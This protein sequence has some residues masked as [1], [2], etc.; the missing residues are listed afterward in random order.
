M[1]RRS[2]QR[3]VPVITVDDDVIV[4]FDRRRLEQLIARDGAGGG[5]RRQEPARPRLGASVAD[6]ERVAEKEGRVAI[7][8]AYVGRVTAGSPA[9]RAGLQPGDVIVALGR[10]PI[11]TAQDVERFM[12]AAKPGQP[13]QVEYLRDGS[14][15]TGRTRL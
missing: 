2:R 15:L 8:G 10:N 11:E 4:G 9:A 6:A 13:L 5:G 3:G 1:I 12:A 7:A 14:R